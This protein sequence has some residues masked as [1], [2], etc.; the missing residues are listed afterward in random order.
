VRSTSFDDA[1]RPQMRATGTSLA[2]N[3]FT[4][5]AT[6]NPDSTIASESIDDVG[7]ANGWTNEY[8]YDAAGRLVSELA[9]KTDTTYNYTLD[10]AGNRTA[11]E[12]VP[13]SGAG[14]STTAQYSGSRLLQV[15]ATSLGY[16][17]WNEVSTDHHGNAYARS[18]DG[19]VTLI[20]NGTAATGFWRN[21][22][23]APVAALEP[24]P[25]TRRTTWGLSAEGLPLEVAQGNGDVLTYITVEGQHIATALNGSVTTVDVD[26][27]TSL[28]RFG[29]SALGA[30]TAFGENATAP[31]G[32]DERYLYAGLER[33]PT[34]SAI[35]LARHRTY[36]PTIGR[37]LEPDPIGSAGGLEV[38]QYAHGDPV[39]FVDPLGHAEIGTV[40]STGTPTLS[41]PRIEPKIP[42]T[43]DSGIPPSVFEE[44][45]QQRALANAYKSNPLYGF[46]IDLDDP[47]YPPDFPSPKGPM[48]VV[49]CMGKV[50][51]LGGENETGSSSNSGTGS[52]TSSSSG[53]KPT[54][55]PTP[56]TP[57][58]PEAPAM[59]NKSPFQALGDAIKDFLENVFS[60]DGGDGES[61]AKRLRNTVTDVVRTVHEN[62]WGTAA[63]EAI[64]HELMDR[65]MRLGDRLAGAPAAL[66]EGARQL[67]NN[68][69]NDPLGTSYA[70][71]REIAVEM[72][73]GTVRD[74]VEGGGEYLQGLHDVPGAAY[75]LYTAENPE[76]ARDAAGDLLDAG[77]NLA[78]GT[79]KLTGPLLYVTGVGVAAR[80]TE[81]I[82]QRVIRSTVRRRPGAGPSTGKTQ[83]L[84][85]LNGGRVLVSNQDSKL[86]DFLPEMARLRGSKA[87]V[88]V[89]TGTHTG[90]GGTIGTRMS[91]ERGRAHGLHDDKILIEDLTEFLH[92]TNIEI[93]DVNLMRNKEI[94]D[95][96]QSPD[97]VIC[98][99]CSSMSSTVV[100]DALDLP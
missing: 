60:S 69:K 15:G 78:S 90:G 67:G 30:A 56:T 17:A 8:T 29:T 50:G 70:V 98:A 44:I 66:R 53:T 21:A 35:M 88:T 95:A 100:R 80:G 93:R 4:W 6:Y 51:S 75:R 92:D 26:T 58:T 33:V 62:V 16:N 10:A 7:N 77:G 25:V 72:V 64:G 27:R 89:L 96:I 13:P 19:R 41:V 2:T 32:S 91:I 94:I 12:V 31:T 85:N 68:F 49:N 40:C 82:T 18:A 65:G 97:T 83:W 54:T 23:G 38:Y 84:E 73:F 81:S 55:P 71:G 79:Y 34:A 86:D 57:T 36:D 14:S 76:A 74:A 42:Q 1:G 37:F 3:D 43:L 28:L 22:R 59:K 52:S 24:G 11:T 61:G 99:W 47:A 20:A 48:C 9:G 5:S 39:N 63:R 46:K 87:P 45:N